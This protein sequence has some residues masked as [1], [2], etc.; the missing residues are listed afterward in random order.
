MDLNVLAVSFRG[1][2]MLST[3]LVF[4]DNRRVRTVNCTRNLSKA[5]RF[6]K[7]YPGTLVLTRDERSTGKRGRPDLVARLVSDGAPAALVI[8]TRGSAEVR[9]YRDHRVLR[10]LFASAD[11][12]CAI[13]TA[14]RYCSGLRPP[15]GLIRDIPASFR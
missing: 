10:D 4:D 8:L 2:E 15:A 12:I 13:A 3:E 5:V 6:L 11:V 14:W 1:G 7:A 9:T